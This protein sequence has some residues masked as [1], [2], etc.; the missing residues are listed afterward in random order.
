MD[1]LL[2]LGLAP[3]SKQQSPEHGLAFDS[4]GDLGQADAY[5]FVFPPPP[6]THTI[7]D[8]LQLVH[9]IIRG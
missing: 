6:P 7:Q 1:S 9:T 4:L 3:M 8:K 5:P 2:R